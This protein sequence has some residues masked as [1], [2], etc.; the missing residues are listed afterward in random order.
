MP[1]DEC[2]AG[3]QRCVGARRGTPMPRPFGLRRLSNVGRCVR[4]RGRGTLLGADGVLELAESPAQRGPAT[5]KPLGSEEQEGH[6]Q[7]DGHLHGP[8]LDMSGSRPDGVRRQRRAEGNAKTNVDEPPDPPSTGPGACRR[9]QG[10]HVGIVRP[11]RT[12][13]L[14]EDPSVV[15]RLHTHV[16]LGRRPGVS[17]PPPECCIRLPEASVS[18]SSVDALGG[19]PLRKPGTAGQ[20]ARI[21]AESGSGA[22]RA[23]D[24]AALSAGL[25]LPKEPA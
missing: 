15:T 23:P 20:D 5:G 10:H 1:R 16:R 13:A 4:G 21:S 8:T 6:D 3:L 7:D 19:R 9:R 24:A 2:D 14:G 22:H 18:P 25:R 11:M 12:S 17:W